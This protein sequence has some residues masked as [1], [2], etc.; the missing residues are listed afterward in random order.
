MTLSTMPEFRHW[1]A[2]AIALA[3]LPPHSDLGSSI[4]ALHSHLMPRVGRTAIDGVSTTPLPVCRHEPTGGDDVARTFPKPRGSRD[5]QE[6]GR[7]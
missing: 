3:V 2:I 7:R 5:T 6:A 1:F 4:A